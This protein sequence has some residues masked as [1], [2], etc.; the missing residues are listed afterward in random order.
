MS[1][2]DLL[3]RVWEPITKMGPACW[4]GTRVLNPTATAESAARPDDPHLRLIPPSLGC[5]APPNRS[6]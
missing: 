3:T 4:I 1:L 5:W 2:V 6:S